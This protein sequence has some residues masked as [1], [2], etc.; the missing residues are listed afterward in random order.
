MHLVLMDMEFEKIKDNFDI[1]MVNITDACT[2]MG[3]HEDIIWIL[4]E[5][6]H[7]VISDLH[8]A[9]IKQFHR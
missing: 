7:C 5:Q 9:G 6:Y 2:H 3:K 1:V 4:Q 8:I